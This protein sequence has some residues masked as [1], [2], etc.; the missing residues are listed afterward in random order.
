MTDAGLAAVGVPGEADA[1]RALGFE[2]DD[3]TIALAN[4]AI[5][6][7]AAGWSLELESPGRDVASIEGIP[8]TIGSAVDAVAHPNGAL[9]I[10]HL[11]IMTDSIER[12]SAEVERALGLE[13]RRL[14]ETATVRQAFHRFAAAGDGTRGC[15]IEVV[16]RPGLGRADMWGLVVVVADIDRIVADSGGLIG[17]PKPAVQPGRRIATVARAAGLPLAVAVMSRP[18]QSRSSPP[19][20]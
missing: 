14:R 19:V 3:D 18:D 13:Q 12:T 16:E 4:G 10:D 20:R 6:P 11:V 5:R 9:D 15:I 17:A 2:V 8:V 7:R 1:W